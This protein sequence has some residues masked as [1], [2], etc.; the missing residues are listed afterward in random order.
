MAAETY[1]ADIGKRLSVWRRL[2]HLYAPTS[3]RIVAL[4]LSDFAWA[5]QGNPDADLKVLHCRQKVLYRYCRYADASGVQKQITKLERAGWIQRAEIQTGPRAPQEYV[6]LVP[7]EV[8]Q[9]VIAELTERS[10]GMWKRI[11]QDDTEISPGT[12]ARCSEDASEQKHQDDVPGDPISPGRHSSNTR[13]TGI[14]HQDDVPGLRIDLDRSSKANGQGGGLPATRP[15]RDGKKKKTKR[16]A[17]D[18]LPEHVKDGRCGKQRAPVTASRRTKILKLAE[19]G[20]DVAAIA[21]FAGMDQ[22]EVVAILREAGR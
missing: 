21:K 5:D 9:H 2:V 19:G 22:A 4:A 11:F 8:P 13:N 10:A 6:L 1:S 15:A 7:P 20:Y 16:P 17:D 12:E 14:D 18:V 3:S